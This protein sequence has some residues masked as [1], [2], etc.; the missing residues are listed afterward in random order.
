MFT[1]IP[2]AATLP[3][4]P[5]FTINDHGLIHADIFSTLDF[6]RIEI[7]AKINGISATAIGFSAYR[8]VTEIERIRMSGLDTKLHVAA[9]T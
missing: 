6:Q 4:G 3:G 8:A 1:E 7:S 9:M 5:G 2:L